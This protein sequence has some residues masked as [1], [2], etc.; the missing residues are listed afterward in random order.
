MSDQAMLVVE[1]VTEELPPKALRQLG[2]AFAEG[3]AAGL[4]ARGYLGPASAVTPFAT[5]R[6][7]AVAVT[8]VHGVAPDAEVIDKLMPA[9]VAF[10]ASGKPTEAYRKKLAGLG[11]P[12]SPT[13]S[14]RRV[15]G[16]DGTLCRLRRQGR[17]RVS[18]RASPK[19]GRSCAACRTRSTRRSASCPSPR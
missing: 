13:S 10:D 1:V 7:L 11:R 18:A 6:R 19:V 2:E 3:I 4:K 14:R 17:L 16:P 9:K 8:H 12:G 15:G 5:P